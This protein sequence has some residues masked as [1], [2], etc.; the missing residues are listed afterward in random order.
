MPQRKFTFIDLRHLNL[1]GFWLI[2]LTLGMLSICLVADTANAVCT[3]NSGMSEI[4][5][6]DSDR[7]KTFEVNVGDLIAIHLPENPTTGYRWEL[8]KV[9]HH[10]VEF[11]CSKYSKTS[12]VRIGGGGMRTF[13]L[14]A[15]SLGTGQIVLKRRRSWEP[16]AKAIDHF[17]VNLV[18]K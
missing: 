11:E 2:A 5:I 9:D 6:L 8:S 15:K 4:V 13:H 10:L 14:R 12:E 3:R 16:E 17:T 1:T 7:A 18:V